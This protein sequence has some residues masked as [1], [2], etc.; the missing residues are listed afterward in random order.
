MMVYL[1]KIAPPGPLPVS[2]KPPDV[3]GLHR[4]IQSLERENV[5]LKTQLA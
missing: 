1:E 3:L 2:K 5:W 4:K